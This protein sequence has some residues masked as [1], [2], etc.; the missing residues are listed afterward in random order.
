M[1]NG[2]EALIIEA[3]RTPVGRGHREKGIFRDVHPADLLGRCYEEVLRRAGVDSAEVDNAI[4]GC[5]YQIAEQSSGITR[6]AWL[7]E[8]LAETTGATT[9]DVR[10]GSGQ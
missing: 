6:L 9:V 1:L 8:G 2:R 4:A 7:Q 10:C 3:V 5:V